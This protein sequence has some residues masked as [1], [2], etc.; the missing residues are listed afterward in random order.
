MCVNSYKNNY[1]F[2]IRNWGKWEIWVERARCQFALR[3][4]ACVTC[5]SWTVLAWLPQDWRT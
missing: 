3:L 1:K 4:R 5:V 2:P